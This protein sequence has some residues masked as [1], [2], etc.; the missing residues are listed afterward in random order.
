MERRMS[1]SD[2]CAGVSSATSPR[3]RLTQIKGAIEAGVVVIRARAYNESRACHG[4]QE[5]V[6][7]P[8]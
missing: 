6:L 4:P 2:I 5:G 8:P 7:K 1:G 3:L